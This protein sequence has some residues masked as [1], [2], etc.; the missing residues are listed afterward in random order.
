M[1]PRTSLLMVGI[2]EYHG[3]SLIFISVQV[4]HICKQSEG[5]Y[6]RLY[7]EHY[8]RRDIHYIW[9]S[10]LPENQVFVTLHILNHSHFPICPPIVSN[11]THHHPRRPWLRVAPA[12]AVLH[13]MHPNKD[14][15][16]ERNRTTFTAY[17]C[18]SLRVSHVIKINCPMVL[19]YLWSFTCH[20]LLWLISWIDI[21]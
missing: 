20:S 5:T 13:V 2:S 17:I 18:L 16:S 3:I 21:D 15:W 14:G 4:T 8:C 7:I 10:I 11:Y 12:M 9:L 19:W 6:L 1:R